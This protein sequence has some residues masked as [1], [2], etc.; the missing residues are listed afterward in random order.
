MRQSCVLGIA[1]S[2]AAFAAPASAEI[3]R[4]GGSITS[5]CVMVFDVPGANKPEPPRAPKAVDCIDGDVTCDEDGLRNG[6]C[7]FSL[8]ACVNSTLYPDCSP[9]SVNSSVVDHAID[10][11]ED[12][13]FDND[14]LALQ[15]RINGFGFPAFG[16]DS[17]SLASAITV[18][19]GG[20]D[21]ANLMKKARKSVR[22]TSTG[23][24]TDDD[25]TDVDK[26]KFT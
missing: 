26:I 14:F 23:T 20:P 7:V 17:C 11:G 24:T 5:D 8:Q 12:P 1:V 19:L 22:V 9:D 4:G 10:N 15:D 13:R 18:R 25:V 3:L 2:L 21:S 6:Q 16:M